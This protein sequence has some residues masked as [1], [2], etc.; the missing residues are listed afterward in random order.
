MCTI[1][2]AQP[3]RFDVAKA[4]E[5]E[6]LHKLTANTSGTHHEH[7]GIRH[8]GARHTE[9]VLRARA[10]RH[11]CARKHFGGSERDPHDAALLPLASG[12]PCRRPGVGTQLL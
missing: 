11:G 6:I 12:L 7:L 1:S 2:K 5:H 9:R 4:A 10:G 3:Y 8:I